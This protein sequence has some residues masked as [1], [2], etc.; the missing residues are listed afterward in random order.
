MSDK[1]VFLP[2]E[3]DN[4][5]VFNLENEE[6]KYLENKFNNVR[7]D[8]KFIINN[9]ELIYFDN[10]STTQVNKRALSKYVEYI[11]K[12]NSN[13]Y[14]SRNKLELKNEQRVNYV[15]NEIIRM[16]DENKE[17]EELRKFGKIE[18]TQ[19]S[20]SSLEIVYENIKKYI[21][22][23]AKE[24]EELK[25]YN[26]S[27]SNKIIVNIMCS[28]EDHKSTVSKF[29]NIKQNISELYSRLIKINI[30]N[31]DLDLS[32]I[33]S[34]STINERL[35]DIKDI[36]ELAKQNNDTVINICI[37]TSI[38]SIT[39]ALSDIEVITQ[40]AKDI[41]ENFITIIDCTQQF[42]H[43]KSF[44]NIA[45]IDVVI[46]SAHKMYSVD[47][48]GI[49]Y[50]SNKISDIIKYTDKNAGSL[51]IG[52]IL[53]LGETIEYI[54]ELKI[55][56]ISK[57]IFYITNYLYRKLKEINDINNEKIIEFDKGMELLG[58]KMNYGIISFNVK[59]YDSSDIGEILSD[60]DIIV[61]E[62]N[63]CMNI[64]KNNLRVSLGIYNNINEID[65]FIDV[66]KKIIL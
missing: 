1:K 18:F 50:I 58:C 40:N 2:L 15:K 25:Q 53:A 37:L 28:N 5:K 12:Y 3:F 30:H 27:K 45:D 13:I 44:M 19:G 52:A 36:T 21:I 64:K 56:D 31:I 63:D 33:Y 48:I 59:G 7:E 54:K 10:A 51:N 20:T 4:G 35:S 34:I 17:D 47:G 61:R 16:I 65:I 66:L 32:G 38:N 55:D 22:D 57:Y 42:K 62:S 41:D 46:F 24:K 39:G 8:F 23:K 29:I 6:I 49:M 9:K 14:R 60:N 43:S 11:E 26:E